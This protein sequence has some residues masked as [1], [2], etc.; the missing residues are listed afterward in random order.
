MS[1]PKIIALVLDK[2]SA[3]LVASR[4]IFPNVFS[5]HVT[6]VYD[7]DPVEIELWSNEIGSKYTF[8]TIGL[9]NDDRAQAFLVSL[10]EEIASDNLFPHITV[11]CANDVRPV[12]SNK[13]L[14]AEPMGKLISLCLIGTVQII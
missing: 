2:A 12:H 1:K 10:P 6:L 8:K 7:A 3:A 5:H 11:S 14:S 9:F 13:M 4:A